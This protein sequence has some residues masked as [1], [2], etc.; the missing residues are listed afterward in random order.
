M[1]VVIFAGSIASLKVAETFL[2]MATPLS[3]FTGFVADTV[4]AVVSLAVPVVKL[5]LKLL[6]SSTPVRFLAPVVIVA[7]YSVSATRLLVG[8]K[9]AVLP[10]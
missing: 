1:D 5:Q 3:P 2:L 7:V 6:A 9:V 8:V 10:T 4:G